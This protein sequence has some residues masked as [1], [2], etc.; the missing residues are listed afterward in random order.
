MV[1]IGNDLHRLEKGYPLIIGG[2]E[3]ESEIGCVAHSDGDVLAHALI[4]SL[5]GAAALGDIGEWFPDTDP[6]YKGI[7][8]II[9][10]QKVVAELSNQGYS[11]S[12]IDAIIMLQTPKL[13]P[14]K[15]MIKYNI[16]EICSLPAERVNIKA[17]TGEKIGII[18]KSEGIEALCIVEIIND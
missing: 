7:S 17:K 11:I 1:G 8:S 5:L 4:D 10:L 9:L 16:A 12:N 6:Q 18:G 14:Y 3:I 15:E 2:I 13:S